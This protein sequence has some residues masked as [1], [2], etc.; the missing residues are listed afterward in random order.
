MRLYNRWRRGIGLL[1]IEHGGTFNMG[2]AFSVAANEL[3]TA[4][5]NL[6]GTVTLSAG[7]AHQRFTQALFHPLGR[8]DVDAAILPVGTGL[9]SLQTDRRMPV[10]GESIAIIGFASVPRRHPTLGIYIGTVESISTDYTRG[11][12]VELIQVSVQASGRLSGSPMFDAQGRV[13]G[14]VIES[15]Y[16]AT[17]PGV[18]SR[19][20]LTVLPIRYALDIRSSRAPTSI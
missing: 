10:V 5:H 8:E 9:P 12:G 15:A 17:S 6:H 4:A 1:E 19:E 13:L 20:F 11:S 18:P 2:T 14:L 16:E 3:L 7:S